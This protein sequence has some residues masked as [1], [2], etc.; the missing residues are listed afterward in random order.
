MHFVYY[1]NYRPRSWA[2]DGKMRGILI[3]IIDEAVGKRLGIPVTHTGYPWK[4]AQYMVEK[5][6]ADAFI[7]IPTMERRA[8]TVIGEEP[9][10]VFTLS[11][12][13]RK[14]HP[15]SM[16][17]EAI[18]SV[19]QLRGYK[20]ADYLGNG[21]AQRNLTGMGVEWLS[22]VDRI[23][24]FLINGRADLVVASNRTIYEM[25]RQ[26]FNTALKVLPNPL[27]SVS[28]H[29]CVGKH[30]PY[31]DKLKDFDRIFKEMHK[32]GTIERIEKSYYHETHTRPSHTPAQSKV[33]R[34]NI[35]H[36]S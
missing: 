18:T 2:E 27:S 33:I 7:T 21:W 15:R 3:D 30:S 36:Q 4:R 14:D 19:K 28:F 29:L 9:I 24:P 13:T 26:G 12:V 23:F 6:M 10:L 32:D 5:G 34:N 17:M 35:P 31:K 1:D 20:I 22:N 8:Y 25:N 16:E 11:I